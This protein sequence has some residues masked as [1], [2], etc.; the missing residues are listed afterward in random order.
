MSQCVSSTMTLL[1]YAWHPLYF[2][3]EYLIFPEGFNCMHPLWCFK[4]G[5]LQLYKNYVKWYSESSRCIKYIWHALLLYV[6]HF[7]DQHFSIHL[8]SLSWRWWIKHQVVQL[9][10]IKSHEIYTLKILRTCPSILQQLASHTSWY[11]WHPRTQ[12]S[13]DSSSMMLSLIHI[14][15]CRRR[16]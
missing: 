8:K 2:V 14:W 10:E 5:V 9:C 12:H 16:G 4:T 3:F 15:R 7:R 11:M 6:F 1:I 13:L